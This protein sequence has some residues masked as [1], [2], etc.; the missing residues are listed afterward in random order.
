MK[1]R[2]LE[3]WAVIVALSL[4]PAPA[5]RVAAKPLFRDPVYDGAADPTA[6]AFRELAATLPA[7]VPVS[8]PQ[9]APF[10]QF[11]RLL[12]PSRSLRRNLHNAPQEFRVHLASGL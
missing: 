7:Q 3:Y 6:D 11:R 5:D 12:T 9:P 1:L 10:T 2:Q 8:N 4:L